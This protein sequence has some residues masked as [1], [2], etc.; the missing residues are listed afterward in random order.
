[1]YTPLADVCALY[2]VHAV[3]RSAL[4]FPIWCCQ[5]PQM[6]HAYIRGHM[7]ITEQQQTGRAHTCC[8]DRRRRQAPVQI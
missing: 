5:L 3:L 7:Q 8:M 1:M 2:S 6:P 4:S